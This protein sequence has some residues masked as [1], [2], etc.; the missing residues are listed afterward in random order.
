LGSSL[1]KTCLKDLGFYGYGS[2]L[3]TLPGIAVTALALTFKEVAYGRV[4]VLE[5]LAWL[6]GVCAAE[7][8]FAQMNTSSSFSLYS[9]STGKK[10]V[11]ME[12]MTITVDDI[13]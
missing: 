2:R 5:F 11:A 4:T 1:V 10:S 8:P 3:A 6:G 9:Q 7:K 12:S 13:C